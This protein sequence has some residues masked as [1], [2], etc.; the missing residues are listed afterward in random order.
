MKQTNKS[1]QQN[2]GNALFFISVALIFFAIIFTAILNRVSNSRSATDLRAKAGFN[3]NLTLSGV[4][5]SVDPSQGVFVIDNVHF[6]YKSRDD[7]QEDL[8]SWTVSPPQGFQL[9]NLSIGNK[10][11]IIANPT[12]FLVTSHTVNATKIDFK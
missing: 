3:T 7:S 8:G 11:E 12:T 5:S 6:V 4:V 2:K 9:S 1:V 10:L